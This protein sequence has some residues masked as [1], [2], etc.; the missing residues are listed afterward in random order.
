MPQL[1]V[2]M[3][4]RLQGFPDEGIF[5]GAKTNAYR[6]VSNAL[7]VGQG[8]LKHSA[9]VGECGERKMSAGTNPDNMQ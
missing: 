6:Q 2:P 3:V 1:T 9:N 4:A 8:L 7:R 5:V